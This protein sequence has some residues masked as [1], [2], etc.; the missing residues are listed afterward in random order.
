M[1]KRK[2]AVD[3]GRAFIRVRI[4][5]TGD[6]ATVGVCPACWNNPERRRE[7]HAQLDLRGLETVHGGDAVD[8]AYRARSTHAPG[9]GKRGLTGARGKAGKGVPE[10]S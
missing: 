4:K 2:K 10:G 6:L 5:G 3:E 7:L 1:R 8:G 9:C